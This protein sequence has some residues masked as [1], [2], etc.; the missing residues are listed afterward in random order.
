MVDEVIQ[1]L[2]RVLAED[3]PRLTQQLC[4]AV[5]AQQPIP[6]FKHHLEAAER[7]L[8][9]G[10]PDRTAKDDASVTADTS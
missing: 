1:L 2:A 9:G 5:L 10:T 7:R 8:A 6:R 4:R 3:R